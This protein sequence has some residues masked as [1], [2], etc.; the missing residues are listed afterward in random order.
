MPQLPAKKHTSAKAPFGKNKPK[1][2][3][4]KIV[5]EGEEWEEF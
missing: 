1:E 3:P 5:K 2:L 4:G